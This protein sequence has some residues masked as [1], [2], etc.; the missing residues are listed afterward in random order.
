MSDSKLP[1]RLEWSI[2]PLCVDTRKGPGTWRIGLD[3]S[4]E[5][6]LIADVYA[7]D[8]DKCRVLA[9]AIVARYNAHAKLVDALERCE[10]YFVACAD[11]PSMALLC[12][13]ALERCGDQG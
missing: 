6:D 3:P 9:D 4:R 12:R 13:R 5:A 7:G 11:A 10:A 1:K 2:G 8:P